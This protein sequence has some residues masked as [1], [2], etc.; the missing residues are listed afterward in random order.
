MQ[1][2]V[3]EVLGRE[4]SLGPGHFD[5]NRAQRHAGFQSYPART[6]V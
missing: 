1:M 3:C 2:K 5:T 4:K 6:V